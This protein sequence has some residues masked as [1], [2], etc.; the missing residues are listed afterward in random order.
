MTSLD[1]MITL[2]LQLLMATGAVYY[3]TDV[4][5][6]VESDR[7][8]GPFEEKDKEVIWAK[9]YEYEGERSLIKDTRFVNLWDRVRRVFGLYDIVKNDPYEDEENPVVTEFWYV[10]QERYQVWQCPLCLGFW[11]S[12]L[13]SIVISLLTPVPH[14]LMYSFL[15]IP[16][17]FVLAG[18]HSIVVS[19]IDAM[20]SKATAEIL[21]AEGD[22]YDGDST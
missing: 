6:L 19:V 3:I 16:L 11:V 20:F 5:L 7:D 4:L 18:F 17:C 8:T 9:V 12:I 14:P 2:F 22:E 15:W 21:F 1:I 10:R 13:P